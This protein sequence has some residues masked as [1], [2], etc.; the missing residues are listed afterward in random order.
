MSRAAVGDG[1]LEL[2]EEDDGRVRVHLGDVVLAEYVVTPPTPAGDSPKPYLHPV[3]TTAGET[4]TAVR[5][6]DHTWHNG[7]QFTMAHLSGENFWGG[8]TYVRG[9]GYTPLDN[10]GTVGHVGWESIVCAAGHCELRH[11]LAW[12][13]AAGRRWLSE[14]RT[15]RFGDVSVDGGHWTLTWSSRLRNTSGRELRWGS[16]VTEGRDTAGYGGL[17]WR[18]PRSFV[19]GTVR[20]PDDRPAAAAMGHRAPWLA[21][22]GRHDESLRS[23]TLLFADSPANRGFPTAW[24][25]RAEPFPVVSFAAT[26]HRPWLLEPGEELTLTHHV[27][28]IDGDPDTAKLSELAARAAG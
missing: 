24:Y 12:R 14:H 8:R 15:L 4:V 3:R 27:V 18:G 16:P 17:F 13:T 25:V 21:F 2:A 9:R 20:T 19:G 5:P 11:E 7:L 26:Y 6:H 1:T 28:V 22:T 23:S 10:N